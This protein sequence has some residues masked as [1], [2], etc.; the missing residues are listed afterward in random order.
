[1]IRFVAYGY[2][3]GIAFL[4]LC[5]ILDWVTPR[6]LSESES[7]ET[8]IDGDVWRVLAEAR[9]ITEESA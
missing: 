6:T 9:R 2:A 3:A 7:V 5:E 1:M 8:S 4:I